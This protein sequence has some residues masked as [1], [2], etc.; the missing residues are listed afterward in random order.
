MIQ[1]NEAKRLR[2]T[3]IA[4]L[5]LGERLLGSN[6]EKSDIYISISISV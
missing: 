2:A 1:E 6:R 3:I 5:K 4:N